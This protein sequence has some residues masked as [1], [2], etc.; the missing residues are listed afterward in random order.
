MDLEVGYQ[1][2]FPEPAKRLTSFALSHASLGETR[3]RVLRQCLVF[4]RSSIFGYDEVT[5]PFRYNYTGTRCLVHY[6]LPEN[7]GVTEY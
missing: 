4:R 3:L 2:R 5:S 6:R 1:S 7:D